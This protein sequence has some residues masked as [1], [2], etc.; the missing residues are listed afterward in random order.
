MTRVNLKGIHKVR[1]PLADGSVREHHYVGRGKGAIKFWD[2]ASGVPIGSSD[3]IAAFSAASPRGTAARGKF[4]A[5]ILGFLDSSDFQGLAPRTQAD[6]RTSIYHPTNGIDVKFGDAP[7]AAFDDPRIRKQALDW[8]DKIGGKVGDDRIRH[9]QRIV[10]F[11][12]D[13]AMLRQHHLRQVKATYKSNRAEVFWLPAEIEAFEKGAPPHVARIL[14]VACETG[15]RPGDLV[16]L[17]PAHLHPTPGGQRL[18]VWTRKRRRLASIPV[19][20]RMAQLIADTPAGRATFLVNKGGHPYQHENYL[21]DAVSSWRDTLKLRSELRLYDARGTA[22]TRLLEAG[23]ELKE[24][25]TH[26][27]WSIK[28]AAEVIERY[29]ALSPAM[30]DGLAAK[31]ALG[32]QDY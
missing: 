18:V 13:R 16:E 28:H 5:V 3:Y 25:A 24:I 27:G 4:R 21:G 9:L 17:G 22:A 31:L 26:M 12:L 15:L 23:A 14:V 2:S 7:V 8:R 1:K 30:T 32:H 19:T 11:G 10:G 29:V 20:P 6:L